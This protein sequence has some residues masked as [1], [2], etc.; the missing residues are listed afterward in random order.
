LKKIII[1]LLVLT[2]VLIGCKPQISAGKAT[3]STPVFLRVYQCIN[4]DWH[5]QDIIFRSAKKDFLSV[6]DSCEGDT[7][8]TPFAVVGYALEKPLPGYDM[9]A[10]TSCYHEEERIEPG[11]FYGTV[12][13]EVAR[14]MFVPE[15]A[16]SKHFYRDHLVFAAKEYA[17]PVGY[18]KEREL[19]YIFTKN[20][21]GYTR[22]IYQLHADDWSN[23][24]WGHVLYTSKV[25]V[26][27]GTKYND[28]QFLGYFLT[29]PKLPI[30]EAELL[31]ENTAVRNEILCCYW[32]RTRTLQT[33]AACL[34]LE[35][36][37]ILQ[38][39][40][41]PGGVDYPTCD[42]LKEQ[43]SWD[44][45]FENAKC[46]AEAIQIEE[47]CQAMNEKLRGLKIYL[48]NLQKTDRKYSN[49]ITGGISAEQ[50]FEQSAAELKKLYEKSPMLLI[51]QY[52][53]KGGQL[54]PLPPWFQ[55]PYTTSNMFEDSYEPKPGYLLSEEYVKANKLYANK[56]LRC[57]SSGGGSGTIW[58]ADALW[59]VEK[60]PSTLP[61][62]TPLVSEVVGYSLKTQESGTEEVYI[63]REPHAGYNFLSK[64]ENCYGRPNYRRISSIGFLPQT[65]DW[66]EPPKPE[67]PKAIVCSPE[68]AAK[69]KADC[70]E[71]IANAR[72]ECQ[73]L[74]SRTKENCEDIEA[75]YYRLLEIIHQIQGLIKE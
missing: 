12:P 70:E 69:I 27:Q 23:G 67:E 64:D 42:Q 38:K 63:C 39:S 75:E 58:N 30:T 62:E 19:G 45:S 3:A 34:E 18:N 40:E 53:Y 4:S 32:M 26:Y 43:C 61:G 52:M 54:L 51:R 17:C 20:F 66:T 72:Q 9:V 22:P 49:Y 1:L 29:E 48:E 8:F 11:L 24:Q 35:G 44:V 16:R 13:E 25:L 47:D 36:S 73:K 33:R 60:C 68:E 56:I 2:V 71:L 6:R 57:T 37:E 46:S 14:W 41:C 55:Y 59:A 65:A 10:L 74:I 5:G 21:P 28:A 31:M 15:Q 50:R 7:A